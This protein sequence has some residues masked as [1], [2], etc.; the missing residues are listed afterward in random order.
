MLV[1][2]SRRGRMHG[3]KPAQTLNAG[4]QLSCNDSGKNFMET[5]TYNRYNSGPAAAA[6]PAGDV[7]FMGGVSPA[8]RPSGRRKASSSWLLTASQFDAFLHCLDPNPEQAAVEFVRLSERLR[9]F[10]A[11]RGLGDPEDLADEAIDRTIRRLGEVRAVKPFVLG[12]ARRLAAEAHR[13]PH[14]V[15]LDSMAE[16]H[17]LRIPEDEEEA[18]REQYMECMT[19]CIEELSEKERTLLIDW[20]RHEGRQ[21]INLRNQMAAALGV[22][23]GHVRIIIFR[24]KAKLRDS[25]YRR[26]SG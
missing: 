9:I 17:Q 2:P 19:T 6:Q 12:V 21:K 26:M 13:R 11:G 23:K 18:R 3:L 22:S 5:T 4:E 14:A 10:F 24:L 16:L 25:I 7:S 20:H 8:L 15:S 1:L